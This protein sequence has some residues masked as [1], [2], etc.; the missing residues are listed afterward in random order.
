MGIKH[1]FMWFRNQ[2]P[3]HIYKLDNSDTL[4]SKDIHID[5]LMIDMNGLFH[6]AAQKVYEY[7]NFKP[8]QRLMSMRK[9]V[10]TPCIKTQKL[11]FQ[12]VCKN[13]DELIKVVQ[14][15]KRLILCVDGTAPLS[16][17]NQQ[18]QRRFRSA[19]ES[20][21]PEGF[22]SNCITPGTKFMDYLTKYIDW[23]IRKKISTEEKWQ[24][25]EIIFSNEKAPGEGEFKILQYIRFYGDPN[26]TFC[27]NGMDAD[28][29]ML[30]LGTHI[31]K[32]YILREDMYNSYNKYFCLN[33][34]DVHQHLAELMRWESTNYEFIPKSAINDFIFLC[35]MVGNDFLPHIPSIEIIEN[36]IELI[37]E[38]YREVGASYGHITEKLDDRLRFVPKA[39]EVFLGTIGQHE[40]EN[41]ELKL[42][43]K[44]NFFADLLLEKSSTQ[45]DG[46]W[47]VDIET[48]KQIYWD[49]SF[50]EQLSE[51]QICHEYLEG[52]QWVLSYYTSGVPNWKWNY[53]Y[54]YA[55]PASILTKYLKTFM[56]K[57]YEHT[58]PSTPYQQ[59]LCVLPPKSAKLIP[60]P[61]CNLLTNSDSPLKKYCPDVFEIDLAG[62]RKEWEGIVLLPIVNFD[63]VK[64]C[65]LNLL[66]QI[67]KFDLKCNTIGRTFQYHY[68][69][70]F[71]YLFKSYYGD[72]E[73]C[74]V[75]ISL[76][77]L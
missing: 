46:K 32:F 4:E 7:G 8:N 64:E 13:I 41:F 35:F 73:A 29:I 17:Q 9:K 22:D 15:S 2:F 39:L 26:D 23:Y 40:K 43:N 45:V 66:P 5:N 51:E 50:N 69:P 63:M 6:N 67:Q 38:I 77:D 55:P 11:L 18:R 52:M 27:I 62:K 60:E 25:I 16:K 74:K 28:L 31:P 21:S 75:K 36:G 20:S 24:N 33:I 49:Q 14:P 1:F 54:H 68:N 57:Q 3:E 59:L 72:I 42:Q 76:I 65:Y 58:N 56:F 70:S 30:C 44:Q 61:L 48:Y 47:E 10:I 12:E 37:L 71:P 34:G 53:K 19:I